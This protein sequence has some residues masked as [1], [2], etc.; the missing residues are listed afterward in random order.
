MWRDAD[1]R[2]RDKLKSV[3]R[4]S[5]TRAEIIARDSVNGV[6][7]CQICKLSIG[8]NEPIHLDHILPLE[9]NGPD[10][11]ENVRTTHKKCNLQRPKD[12]R[13]E[14]RGGKALEIN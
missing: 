7:I 3:E 2:R 8:Q 10:I 9:K 4:I 13:D 12:G 14:M 5:Y 1:K 6:P 11:P